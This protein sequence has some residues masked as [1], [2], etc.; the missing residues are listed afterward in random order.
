MSQTRDK[1]VV[2]ALSFDIEDWFHMVEIDAVAD[3]RKWPELPSI[4]VEYTRW[5]VQTLAD[6]DVKAT[7]FMLG[8][9]AERYPELVREIAQL[10]AEIELLRSDTSYVER[11]ARDEL[12]MVRPEEFVFQFP[13]Q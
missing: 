8:W 12:G 3:P 7:F 2:N 4:V 13:P 5:I 6:A 10:K 9:I 1:H 11:I